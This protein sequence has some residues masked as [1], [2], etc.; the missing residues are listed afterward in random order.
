MRRLLIIFVK[1]PQKGK[2]KT[3]LATS[4]GDEKALE[5]YLQLL[6][7]TQNICR[8]LPADKIVYYSDFIDHED[9][10]DETVYQKALQVKTDLGIRM[11]TAFE[12]AFTQGYESV[13]I[14]GS[15][16]YELNQNIL[17]QAF[18]SLQE[19]E[20][21]IG[22]ANDGGY[23]L[24]GMNR[25]HPELFEHKQWS[26]SSVLPDTLQDF[27]QKKCSFELLPELT[28]IDN[29]KDLKRLKT[30]DIRL[31]TMLEEIFKK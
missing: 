27:K 30:K 4:I 28:D 18:D 25:L 22:P 21:V 23:Y 13:C 5:V 12:E 20:A 6:E 15:D 14:I 17:Q 10:W 26:T 31:K 19:H 1:N 2:V 8:N 11:K 7:R 16:C 9:L 3:R 29:E 24:L